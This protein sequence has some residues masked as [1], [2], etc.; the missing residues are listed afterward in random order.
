M[1]EKPD[2]VAKFWEALSDT[3]FRVPGLERGI[4]AVVRAVRERDIAICYDADKSTHPADLAERIRAE[5][6]GNLS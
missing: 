3:P 6:D 4:A 2:F 5:I 1:T